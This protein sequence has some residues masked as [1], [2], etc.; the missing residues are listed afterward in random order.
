MRS[1]SRCRR[2]RQWRTLGLR[3]LVAA[4]EEVARLGEAER[5]DIAT[6]RRLRAR[7]A[8]LEGALRAIAGVCEAPCLA[9]GG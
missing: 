9:L 1:F 6:S 3:R 8:D 7:V 2:P 4:E 5:I